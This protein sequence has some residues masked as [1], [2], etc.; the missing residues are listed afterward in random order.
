[1]FV[2]SLWHAPLHTA[3]QE[4]LNLD[5]LNLA[6]MFLERYNEVMFNEKLQLM[7]IPNMS[8]TGVSKLCII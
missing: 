2:Q 1:M 3:F 4:E 8:S 7:C 5:T 6:P